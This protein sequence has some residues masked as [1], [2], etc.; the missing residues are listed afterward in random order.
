MNRGCTPYF[1]AT[2]LSRSVLAQAFAALGHPAVGDDPLLL[3]EG[4]G[5]FGLAA[6]QFDNPRYRLH[7]GAVST[8]AA[9]ACARLLAQ[10]VK[11]SLEIG[12]RR[13][14]APPIKR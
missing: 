2:S 11:P 12:A 4:Q 9:E 6:V 14:G 7:I 3:R 10:F 1:W 13:G 8:V 5:E